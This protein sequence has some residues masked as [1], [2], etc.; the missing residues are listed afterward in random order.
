ML[1]RLTTR[2][3]NIVYIS[4]LPLVRGIDA[5]AEQGIYRQGEE[6][7]EAVNPGRDSYG[8]SGGVGGSQ[9]PMNSRKTQA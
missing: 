8:A 4:K 1:R 9:F 6:G 7:L 2:A 3:K 5:G